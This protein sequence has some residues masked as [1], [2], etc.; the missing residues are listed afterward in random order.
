MVHMTSAAAEPAT[1]KLTKGTNWGD[2]IYTVELDGVKVG[3]V[4]KA[5]EYDSEPGWSFQAHTTDALTTERIVRSAKTR[6]DCIMDGV[7]YLDIYRSGWVRVSDPE[8]ILK[9]EDKV[10][11]PARLKALWAKLLD[12]KYPTTNKESI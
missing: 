8:D 12:E 9:V 10:I 3:W 7:S 1:L 4:R 11:E 2:T 6:R 5:G